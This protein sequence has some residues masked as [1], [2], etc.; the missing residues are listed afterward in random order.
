MIETEAF[1]NTNLKIEFI[2]LIKYMIRLSTYIMINDICLNTCINGIY[3]CV[4]CQVYER[5]EI[6]SYKI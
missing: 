6:I 2:N 1:I 3:I 5:V 4:F